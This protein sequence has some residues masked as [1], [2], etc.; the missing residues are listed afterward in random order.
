[1]PPGSARRGCAR[2]STRCRSTPN[3]PTARSARTVPGLHR[4][5][6]AVS[7]AVFARPGDGRRAGDRM[8]RR[9]T[10]SPPGAG[11]GG[12]RAGA[13]RAILWRSSASIRRGWRRPNRRRIVSAIRVSCWPRRIMNRGRCW[14]RRCCRASGSIGT[15]AARLPAAPRGQSVPRL[16]R[17]L[18]RRGL[19]RGGAHGHRHHRP[20]GGGHHA[21]RSRARMMTRV[22]PLDAVRVAVLGRRVSA[23]RLADGCVG[24][25]QADP[26]YTSPALRGVGPR[27]GPTRRAERL[28][29]EADQR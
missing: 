15:W 3:W 20:R 29:R 22:H 10:R 14:S 23:A 8:A 5:G 9:C 19:R 7:R 2:R 16:D 11:G 26:A 28:S 1:M 27:S 21:G 25:R 6:R 12:G 13:A 4:A 17:H 24:R 18:R